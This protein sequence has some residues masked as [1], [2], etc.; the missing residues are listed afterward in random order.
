MPNELW[1]IKRLLDWTTDH[2]TKHQI[3]NPHLEAEILLAHAL[4]TERIKLYIDFEKEP[5]RVALEIFKG[6]IKRRTKREPAAYITGNKYFMSLA[7]KVTRDVL[8]PRPETELLIENA[9]E[10][11]KTFDRVSALDIGTGSGAI[12]V[13][14][15]RFIDNMDI[16]ATDSS[17][18]ALELALENAKK[19][20]V[21]SRIKFTETNLFPKEIQKFNII[22]S[23]PPYIKTADIQNLAPE[24]RD[25]EP[26]AALDGGADG[27]NYYRKI[28]EQAE[29][30]LKDDG[31]LL[32]EIGAGQSKDVVG[33][34]NDKL[35]PKSI[36]VKKDLSGLDRVVIASGF[37]AS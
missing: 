10:L 17:Q 5:D 16:C 25:F 13:S 4:A 18:K 9:I 24:I 7:F 27:L 36:R 28:A 19:H 14:L 23:N 21:E 29:T 12:A 37:S 34:I 11:S 6:F 8:I 15:A 2:F 30:Y 32:L 20:G 31:Y 22:I 33:I 26:I 3:E 1:T 35:K